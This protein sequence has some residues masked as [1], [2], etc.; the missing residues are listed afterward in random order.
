M[1]IVWLAREREASQSLIE[2]FRIVDDKVLTFRLAWEESVDGFRSEPFSVYRFLLHL[3]QPFIKF[4]FQLVPFCAV[5]VLGTSREA[6][7]FVYVEMRQDNFEWHVI[8]E[9][10]SK[11][12]GR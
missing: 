12:G 6:I 2:V 4:G 7:E 9:A 8:D 5:S 3:I 11:L 10:H 1:V